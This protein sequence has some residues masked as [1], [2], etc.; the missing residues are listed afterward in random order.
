MWRLPLT[1]TFV[2]TAFQGSADPGAPSFDCAKA[3][4]EDE[5]AICADPV[6]GAL[7]R[8]LDTAYRNA[9]GRLRSDP[10]ALKHLRQEQALML[11]G[12]RDAFAHP[13]GVGLRDYLACWRD[14]LDRLAE[15][16]AG[17][18]GGWTSLDTIIE[19]KGRPDGR[20][21]VK[22]QGSDPVRGSWTCGYDGVGEKQGERLVVTWD[23]ETD[24]EDGA[25]G[26][27]LELTRMG[28]LL[29]V[30]ELPGPDAAPSPPYCGVH[31]G[32]AGDYMPAD[33]AAFAKAHERV[34][35]ER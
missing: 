3:S 2:L 33:A 8:S 16:R 6:L 7:D 24:D 29:R 28:S 27:V 14:A 30:R 10:A 19:V 17:F 15:P 1:L 11:A 25:D 5:K 32:L 4:R 31:G 18:E 9:R 35:Y 22:L 12:R 13:S 34:G 23:R 21:S 20:F 26:W